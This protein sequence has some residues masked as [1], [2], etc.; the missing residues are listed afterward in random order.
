MER[1]FKEVGWGEEKKIVTIFSGKRLP[2]FIGIW[3]DCNQ[4]EARTTTR[5]ENMADEDQAL[6]THT[7]KRNRKKEH[8]SP[9]KFKNG[10]RDNSNIRCYCC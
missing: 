5:E 7:G 1:P 8:S 9:K 2:K 3:E 10:Q 4:E 6:A